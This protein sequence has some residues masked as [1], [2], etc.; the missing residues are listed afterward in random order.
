MSD[1]KLTL[2]GEN[3]DQKLNDIVEKKDEIINQNCKLQP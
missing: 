1:I 2:G 3:E